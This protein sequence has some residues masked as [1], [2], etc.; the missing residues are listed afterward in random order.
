MN[1][2]LAGLRQLRHYPSAIIGLT[3]V[4]SL[5]VLS[6]VTVLTIPYSE[7]IRLWRGGAGVWDEFP[8]L[9]RPAWFQLFN[10]RKLPRTIIVDTRQDGKEVV[11]QPDGTRLM[12]ANLRFEF[13]YDVLPS[14]IGLWLS[15]TAKETQP[16]VMLSW[17]KPN[18]EE[19]AFEERTPRQTERYFVS[20]DE[21][22]REHLKARSI[23]EALFSAGSGGNDLALRGTYELAIEGILF[24]PDTDLDARLVVYGKVHGFAGTDV[25]RRD[26]GVAL[27]WGTPIALTFGLLAAVGTTVFSLMI[28]AVGTWFGGRL[29][30]IIQRITEV[31]AMLPGLTLL[32][33]IGMFYSRSLW[34]M[35][36]AIILLSMFSL[37]IKTY[38]AIFL[39]LKEAPYIEA[40][41][42]YGAGGFRIVF[43]YMIPRVIP[44]LIPAFVTAI[45]G[46]V[47]LEASLSILGLGDPD[48]PTWGKLLSDAYANEALYKG[49]YYWVLEPAA[50]LMITGMSFA[51]SGFALDRMFNPRLRT[52]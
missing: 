25:Q 51:M 2:L 6:L 33:M 5:L 8:E 1:T 19:I 37:G 43:R 22:L 20:R 48:I 50:L 28:S 46:F 27:L 9:A 49:Y 32:V 45:P 38:R 39:S 52:A 11:D 18:G 23:E 12:N 14:E 7:A 40:A 24:E 10:S 35:L 21:R 42:A 30:A 34:V 36:L 26:L 44:M 31:N 13:P 17:R 3:I 29:D 41:R 4:F 16:F 15:T 47:F